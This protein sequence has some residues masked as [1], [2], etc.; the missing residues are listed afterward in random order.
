MVDRYSMITAKMTENPEFGDYVLYSDYAALQAK[1]T[2]AEE[3]NRVL[4]ESLEF[5]EVHVRNAN[6]EDI[7]SARHASQLKLVKDKG[8][9]ARQALSTKHDE[10]G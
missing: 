5:Y 6:R 4:R 10:E 9:I 7:F 2:E 3:E 1:L 8:Q